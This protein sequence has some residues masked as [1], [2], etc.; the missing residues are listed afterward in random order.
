MVVQLILRKAVIA[1]A[2]KIK[3]PTKKIKAVFF[4]FVPTP[5]LTRW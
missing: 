1:R 3:D 5:N 2:N 4:G